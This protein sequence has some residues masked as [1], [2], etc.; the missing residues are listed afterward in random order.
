MKALRNR[1]QA[2]VGAATVVV[3]VLAVLTAYY[4]DSLPL[5]SNSTTYSAYFAESAG[6]SSD[7]D[8]QVAGVR[9]GEVSDVELAGNKV[10]VDFT[11]EDE[12]VGDGSKAAIGIKTLLGEK[13][14]EL[15]P[16]GSGS[17]NPNDPIPVSRT[18]TPFELQDVFD[19][20]TDTV[21]DIDTGRLSKSFDVL[22][23]ALQGAPNHLR[24][25]VDG[26]SDLSE[27][28]SSRDE[29]LSD[30]L[31]NTSEVSDILSKRNDRIR[32]VMKDGNLLLG[33][34]Q[35][36]RNS[37]DKLLEG[38]QS[39]S[40]ELSG[41][42]A[43]NK[44]QLGPA[45]Q[46]LGDLTKILE[47]N[48]GNLDRSLEMLAPFV[49]LGSNAI[50]NGQWFEGYFCGLLPPSYLSDALTVNKEGCTQPLAAPDQG[51]RKGDN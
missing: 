41:L 49:R 37:I 30:L 13:Y 22:T 31:S 14:L 1:N 33:E 34:L 21:G 8:V 2:A 4:S 6:L 29:Q 43:D 38:T 20:L 16:E 28:I 3:L 7:D 15:R 18:T 39:L 42:V 50:G 11:V 19:K 47:N 32:K 10:L 35:Q 23:D 36:R 48:K 45:L 9:V 26:L 12:R 17:Q 44:E 46:K 24:T 40:D 5:L 51:V 27:T 25:A